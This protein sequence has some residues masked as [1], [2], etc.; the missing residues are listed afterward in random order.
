[1]PTTTNF[2]QFSGY[3]WRVRDSPSN[4]GNRTNLYSPSNAWTDQSGALHLR[5][6]KISDGWSC[7]EVTLMRSLG[8]GNY[9]FVVRDISHLEPTVAFAMFTFDYAEGDLNNREMGIEISRWGRPEA[10]NAQYVLQPFY[11][12]ANVARFNVPTG[13]VTHS[14]RWD[15]GSVMFKTVRGAASGFS[16]V[17]EHVFTVGVPTPGAESPR[18]SLYLYGDADRP[19]G[20]EVE[21]VIEKFE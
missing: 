6:A 2:L 8:Y 11:V 1:G 17:S 7:A 12:A 10:E 13:V 15:P 14:F 3:E 9:S 4:R 20:N 16:L 21:V 5:I 18:M 19:A